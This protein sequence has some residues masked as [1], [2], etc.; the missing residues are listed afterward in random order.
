MF[1]TAFEYWS[2]GMLYGSGFITLLFFF[3]VATELFRRHE[4]EMK[5][6]D[7]NKEIRRLEIETK[8][9]V[10]ILPTEQE[11][12][13]E[14]S[15]SFSPDNQSSVVSVATWIQLELSKGHE[16]P[17]SVRNLQSPLLFGSSTRQTSLGKLSQTQAVNMLKRLA[18]LGLIQGRS[19]GI[20]GT[21]VPRSV[22][23]AVTMIGTNW[24]KAAVK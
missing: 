15:D 7:A 20:A 6:I 9:S 12:V 8:V 19:E 10:P 5:F 16:T 11:T 21:W 1:G 22:E 3:S 13:K 24:S 14:L 2:I 4:R 23:E 17:Y 18:D